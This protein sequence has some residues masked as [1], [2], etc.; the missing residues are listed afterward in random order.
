MC[1]PSVSSG[2]YK[3]AES[4]LQKDSEFGSD[5]GGH[6]DLLS[7]VNALHTKFVF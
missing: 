4:V 3:M 6:K 1:H 2:V 5:G 7:Q